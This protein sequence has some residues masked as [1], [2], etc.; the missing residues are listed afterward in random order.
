M[1]AVSGSNKLQAKIGFHKT[2]FFVSG[3]SA[4]LFLLSLWAFNN[5]IRL[6]AMT[7]FAWKEVYI[8][9]QVHLMLAYANS[10]LGKAD[11]L[12]WVGP[13]G[14]MGGL[15]GTIGGLL[16]SYLAKAYGTNV[17]LLWGVVLVVIPALAAMLLDYIPGS[18]A[19]KEKGRSPLSSIDLPAL[20]KYVWSIAFITAMSQFVI[21]IAD[22]KFSIIFEQTIADS[23]L[24]TAYLGQVYTITNG[25]TLALQLLVLP[26]GLKYISEKSLHLFIPLSYMIC[27]TLGLGTGAGTLFTVSSLYIFMKASDYSLFSSAKELL[28][29]PLQ[30][31]Q[32]YGAK[33]LTDM[34][35]YR[36]A[37]AT[38]A[39]VLLY[40]QSPLL[41]NGMM[42]FF[43]GIWLVMV[44]IT[45]KQHS[46]LFS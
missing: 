20:K 19:V 32:K 41:L 46:K 30:P 33:Y 17:T 44:V 1:I 16:T 45:F 6:G 26:L 24:R 5:G 40:F 15:G 27:L 31:L 11:F 21:N 23:S 10:W 25:L 18:L 42:I 34:V 43:M 35:V 13:I 4:L 38:I 14:A 39:V 3:F 2:F 36:A 9:L 28:Y 22:F 12:K 7:L 29:H 37:K 8:V